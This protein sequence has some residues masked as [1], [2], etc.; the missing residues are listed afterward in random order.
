MISTVASCL[1][2][3]PAHWACLLQN[4]THLTFI[5]VLNYLNYALASAKYLLRFEL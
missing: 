4:K 1:F 5:N 3:W 2:V